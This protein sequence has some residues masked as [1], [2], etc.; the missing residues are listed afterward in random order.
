MEH[1]A[2]IRVAPRILIE[3]IFGGK[4]ARPDRAVGDR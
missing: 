2:L 4:E 3:E 1:D